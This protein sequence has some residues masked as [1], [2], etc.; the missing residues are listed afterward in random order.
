TRVKSHGLVTQLG[1]HFL[2]E[3]DE[4]ALVINEHHRFA[5]A[6][7]QLPDSFDGRFAHFASDRQPDLEP[8][9]FSHLRCNLN[10]AS[11]VADDAVHE[12]QAEAGAGADT[13]GGEERIEHS[14][15]YRRRDAGARISD[16][17]SYIR[18]RGEAAPRKRARRAQ[19]DAIKNYAEYAAGLHCL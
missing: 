5:A 11:K 12:R 8:R 1:K 13:L 16:E 15:E 14:L 2:G 19:L 9:P 3:R 7:R 17:Q 18:A 10:R 4:R 6:A